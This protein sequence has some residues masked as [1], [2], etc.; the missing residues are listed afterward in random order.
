MNLKYTNY[1]PIL[2]LMAF[3]FVAKT[4]AQDVHY[5]QFHN[6]PLYQSPA[7]TGLMKG[8]YRFSGVYRSQWE[9]VPVQYRTFALGFDMKVLETKSGVL[10]AGLL[11][12]RDQAGDSNLSLTTAILSL[13]YTVKLAK[14]SLLTLG[15]NAGG[16]Q[17][18]LDYAKLTFD[19]QFNGDQFIA[20]NATGENM[21]NTQ[22]FYIDMGAGLNYRFQ[23]QKRTKL[24]IGVAGFHF[25]QPEQ[26]FD[27]DD[28][29]GLPIRLSTYINGSFR[30][31]PK[32][33]LLLRGLMHSQSSYRELAFGG[34]W[35]YHLSERKSKE[36]SIAFSTHYRLG[37]AV[38]PMIEVEYG[39]WKA[40]LS[41]D[42]NVSDF[43]IATDG[44]G[45]PEITLQYIITKVKPLPEYKACPIF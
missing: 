35:R 34:G 19:N 2:I 41:Y 9:S 1:I 5:S 3:C 28:K 30:L 39:P 38:I 8:D 27:A 10:G 4:K 31:N 15:V 12:T 40:G 36:T 26:A 24:D 11:L 37:D 42:I 23:T 29:I 43:N 25:N 33:D 44:R 14:K 18:S 22:N 7:Q 17:R 32:S 21:G 6:V 20:T 45:G 13:A 16:G